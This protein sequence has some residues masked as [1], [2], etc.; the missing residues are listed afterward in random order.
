[1]QLQSSY[2]QVRVPFSSYETEQWL[3]LCFHMPSFLSQLR[4]H[5]H[6]AVYK[7]L[8]TII[9]SGDGMKVRRIFTT[10]NSIPTD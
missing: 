3:N 8:E 7:Q 10:K 5:N 2:N 6:K 1:M 9:L 4:Q